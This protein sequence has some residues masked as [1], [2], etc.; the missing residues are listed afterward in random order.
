[1]KY[2]AKNLAT[3]EDIGEIT[4][5]VESIKTDMVK[6]TEILKAQLSLQNQNKY[7]LKSEERKALI[8]FHTKL[9]NWINRIVNTN[10]IDSIAE[11]NDAIKSLENAYF[12]F[13]N[14]ECFLEL[15]FQEVNFMELK[16]KLMQVSLEYQADVKKYY[17]EKIYNLISYE[18]QNVNDTDVTKIETLEE[19]HAKLLNQ[20]REFTLA[21]NVKYVNLSKKSGEMT[22]LIKKYL[23]TINEP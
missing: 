8:D 23:Y 7:S 2:K 10:S 5:I 15:F 14:A 16:S 6:D 21:T 18:N 19:H 12:E 11:L 4:K 20:F 9:Y 3:K 1:M 17:I 13:K 22:L